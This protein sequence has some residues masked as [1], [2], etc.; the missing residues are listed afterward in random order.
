METAARFLWENLEERITW[1]KRGFRWES[2]I[3]MYA[4]AR[5]WGV[6]FIDLDQ[7]RGGESSSCERGG[8]SWSLKCGEFLS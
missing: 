6:Y 8:P 3:I 7:D 1:K 2:N 4:K 5:R